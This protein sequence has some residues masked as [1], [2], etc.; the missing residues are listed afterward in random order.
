MKDVTTKQQRICSTSCNSQNSLNFECMH[1]WHQ[2][3]DDFHYKTLNRN[4]NFACQG[5]KIEQ[6][7]TEL[8]SKVKCNAWEI[9]I[10]CSSFTKD[11]INFQQPC[12]H[13]HSS[14]KVD[15]ALIQNGAQFVTWLWNLI[16]QSLHSLK[17]VGYDTTSV[18]KLVLLVW[19]QSFPSPRL[20]GVQ[21]LKSPV[22]TTIYP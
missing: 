3:K 17:Q 19:T 12:L 4:M 13:P 1:M 18:L 20:I 6:K 22:Y 10:W 5:W 14:I 21:R 11:C 2:N 16:F 8:R 9:D 7:F 15:K